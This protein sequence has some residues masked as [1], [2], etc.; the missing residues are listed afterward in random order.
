MATPPLDNEFLQYWLKLT[1]SEKES[2]L[3]IAKQFVALKAENNDTDDLQ[4]QLLMEEKAKYH[5]GEGTSSNQAKTE[6]ITILNDETNKR[7]LMQID[8]A[9]LTKDEE[10]AEDL[11]DLV[12]IELRKNED[13]VSWDDVKKQLNIEGKL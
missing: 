8:L 6:M 1:N 9:E 13:T 7:R 11:C 4:K 2:L 12:A 10:W 5:K 3:N